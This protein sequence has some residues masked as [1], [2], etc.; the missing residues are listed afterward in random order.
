MSFKGIGIALASIVALPTQV[1]AA[2]DAWSGL[3][4][5]LDVYDGSIDYLSISRT[6]PDTY[7]LRVIPSVIS[8]C[9]TG[10]GWIVA[11]GILNNDG[12]MLRQNGRVFCEGEDPV[13]VS[14][15]VLTREVDT[16]IIRYGATDDRRPLVY[17]K[18]STN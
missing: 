1:A 10:R 9:E 2:E 14:D 17:H 12:N 15:R 8:L 3:Y 4:K 7:E 6:G 11:D 5:G 16:G 18:I 13:A